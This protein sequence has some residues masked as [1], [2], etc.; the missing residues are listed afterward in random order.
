M[1]YDVSASV[2]RLA[3]LLSEASS[4]DR[5]V[6]AKHGHLDWAYRASLGDL[7][8]NV[9][10]GALPSSTLADLPYPFVEGVQGFGRRL[11]EALILS[12]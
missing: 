3:D 11:H 12:G 1:I 10:V 9:G 2:T 8:Q 7:K 6:G 4:C 5:P